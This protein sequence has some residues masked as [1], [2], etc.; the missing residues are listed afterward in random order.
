MKNLSE[1][2]KQA[3]IKRKKDLKIGALI[4]VGMGGVLALFAL[5]MSGLPENFDTQTAWHII[6]LFGLLIALFGALC[7]RTNQN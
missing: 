7:L 1:L 2:V 5:V 3:E 4:L 6:N